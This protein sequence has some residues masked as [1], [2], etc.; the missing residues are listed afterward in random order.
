MTPEEADKFIDA[1][2]GL[3]N[4]LASTVA[5]PT[6]GALPPGPCFEDGRVHPL[7]IE[8]AEADQ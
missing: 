5:C 2:A 1:F 6:C 8:R 3:T 4:Y 7:R